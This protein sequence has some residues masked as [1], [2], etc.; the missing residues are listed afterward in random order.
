MKRSLPEPAPERPNTLKVI[1]NDLGLS[2]S[3][4]SLA[5]SGRPGVSEATRQRVREAA[6]AFGYRRSALLSGA[7]SAVRS[8]GRKVYRETIGC[9]TEGARLDDSRQHSNKTRR[10]EWL[11][12][13]EE[14]AAQYGCD[15]DHFSLAELT[16]NRISEV[17]HARAIQRVILLVSGGGL[18]RGVV[19]TL[20]EG[21][22]GVVLG[23]TPATGMPTRYVR[24]DYFAAGQTIFLKGWGAG[25]RRFYLWS[26]I[27]YL[28]RDRRFEA[29]M[30]FAAQ[31][32][33]E[34]SAVEI[35]EIPQAQFRDPAWLRSLG[36][37]SCLVGGS[38]RDY[39]E[40]LRE[41][42][43][44]DA[45][46]W[47]DWH[48][49]LAG[50]AGHP[51]GIDQHDRRQAREAVA[52]VLAAGPQVDRRGTPIAS[53]HLVQPDWIEGETLRRRPGA[54]PMLNAKRP[55]R[56]RT[57]GPGT[58]CEPLRLGRRARAGLTSIG[59][60]ARRR[61]LPLP[62][63]GEQV[64]HGIPFVIEGNARR[65][66]RFVLCAARPGERPGVTATM[67]LPVRRRAREI[68]FLHACAESD[69]TAM[70]GSYRIRLADG[71]ELRIPLVLRGLAAE[72][73]KGAI[74]QNWWPGH[75]HFESENVRPICVIDTGIDQMGQTGYLY[76]LRWKNP[77]PKATVESIQ[78]EPDRTS[79]MLLLLFGV[80]LR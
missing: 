7:M 21:R 80:T 31:F 42:A 44:A 39:G 69:G 61:H 18:E 66:C 35:R 68:F 62:P 52:L 19:D 14:G 53:T 23:R 65:G 56:S 59:D 37:D 78:I 49:N 77:R 11:A 55:F 34:E 58:R 30:R 26:V 20:L 67:T 79:P 6:E 45:P 75:P 40:F 73:N 54:T 2:V 70:A 8:G 41:F 72:K 12:G 57:R 28:N 64:F 47:I 27:R 3:A 13:I 50:R 25:Y 24:C 17:L 36:P 76:L 33:P 10:T 4:V 29:G 43:P 16:E 5:L 9:V 71:E 51:T 38:G 48:A 60:P 32:M 46:G 74:L 63:P 15:L 22:Q 1:A